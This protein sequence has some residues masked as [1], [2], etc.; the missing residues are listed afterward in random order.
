MWW[1]YMRSPP[2]TRS[3]ATASASRRAARRRTVRSWRMCSSIEAASEVADR[4][5]PAGRHLLPALVNIAYK[6][7]KKDSPHVDIFRLE[8]MR[9]LSVVLVAVAVA[10][11]TAGAAHGVLAKPSGATYLQ[12]KD[13]HGF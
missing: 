8:G 13:G 6:F 3:E 7:M 1:R 9:R 11:S 10:A 12:L 5:T 4:S 2:G